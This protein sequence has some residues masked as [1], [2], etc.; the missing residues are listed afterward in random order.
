VST[1]P[2]NTAPAQPFLSGFPTG[3]TL[4]HPAD[5][6]LVVALAVVAGLLGLAFK[7][8]LYKI[9]DICDTLWD[10]RPMSGDFSLTLP[11]MLAVAIASALSRALSYGTIYTTKLL[12]RGIDLD[13]AL[14][15]PASAVLR[16]RGED[17]RMCDER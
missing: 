4:P 5:Y 1:A 10:G 13:G 16:W 12:R 2:S 3:I 11:V 14:E 6:L 17:G 9:E 8:V 7:T 15:S